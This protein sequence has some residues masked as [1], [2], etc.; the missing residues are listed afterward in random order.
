MNFNN[1]Y[2]PNTFGHLPVVT[3]N[4]IIINVLLFA[5]K[6]ILA[7][8]DIN[9]DDYLGLHDHL[10]PNFKI[11]QFVTYIFMHGSV[12]H[13]FFNMFGVYIFGQ[14]LEQIWG[15]RRYLIF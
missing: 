4:I 15:P 14:V 5:A 9:L 6:V 3:K 12:S 10:A 1:Q 7:Q 2:R 13:I 8:R 11:H